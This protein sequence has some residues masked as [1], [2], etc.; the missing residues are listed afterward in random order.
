MPSAPLPWRGLGLSSNLDPA[1]PPH[2]YRL[3]DA[4]P[5]L[6]DFV[7]YSAPLSLE[8]A[9]EGA[10]LFA[11]LW[12]RRE[13]VPVLFH[14]VHLNLW[15]PELEPPAVLALL[16]AHLR[17][18]GS[19]W[20]GND[21]GWWHAGGRPFPGYLF[22]APPL[23]E[24]G[25]ADAAAH[26]LHVQA[27]LSVPLVLENPPVLARRGELH[28]LD[29]MARLHA[30]TGAPLLLD[31]GHLWSHQLAAGLPPT[32]GLDGF[33]LE[34]VVEVHLAG[35]VVTGPAGGRRVYVDDHTQPVREE[36]FALLEALLPRLPALRALTF[37]GDGHPAEVAA[38][39]LRRLRRLL[40]A[41]PGAPALP[42][43]HAAGHSAPYAPRADAWEAFREAHAGEG[44]DGEGA[45]AEQD[46]RL[47]VLAEELDA[48]APLTRLLLAGT[49]EGLAAFATSAEYRA[50]FRPGG[51]GPAGALA[52]W[53]RRRV[54]EEGL[55]ALA[56][57]LA[58]E[59]A[60]EHA[61]HHAPAP[62]RPGE[63][64]LSAEVRVLHFPLD[65]TELAFA[66]R[67]LRRHLTGRGWAS[68]E[69]ALS[70]L[71]ALGQVAARA[72]RTPWTAVAVRR[73]RAF[74][75]AGVGRELAAALAAAAGGLPLG[76][77][78]SVAPAEVWRELRR[79]G[80]LRLPGGGQGGSDAG[81]HGGVQAGAHGGGGAA[82]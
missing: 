37:E 68:G 75:V 45:R 10:P 43:P 31:L 50:G 46:F 29:F 58:F 40:P 54:R 18:V 22:L 7:E 41:R 13:R 34:A 56:P 26:A 78:E 33:P 30:R 12:A 35:G 52:A 8:E 63:V 71:E 24:A 15:G 81:A 73:G 44:A 49:R 69:V 59:G 4:E 38:L 79:R 61:A 65:L 2:P 80:W 66:A 11:E 6:F 57:V 39:T 72:P 74:E 28:V 27:H 82:G 76:H 14:P 64:A 42:V 60:L 20:V 70:G 1:I 62:P 19:A 77:L 51:Q 16:D 53:A 55:E 67:A 32:A 17:A 9:R 25:L 3:L 5:G 21:V 36:L 47:A 23:S 48:A